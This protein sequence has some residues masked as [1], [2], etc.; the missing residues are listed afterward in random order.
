VE[1]KKMTRSAWAITLSVWRALFLRDAIY[2]LFHR[3]GA[4]VWL[5]LEPVL[6][7]AF[8]VFIFTV[9]RVKVVGGID[10]ALWLLAGMLG[11]FMFRRTMNAS[12]A[13]IQMSRALFTYRQVKPV[14]SVLVRAATEGVLMFIIALAIFIGAAILGLDVLPDNGFGV[15]YAFFTLWLLG[16][17]VGLLMSV[18]KVIIAEIGDVFNILMTPLYLLSGV[19]FPI[20]AVPQPYRDWLLLNPIVH[21]LEIMRLSFATHYVGIS[22]LDRLYPLLSGLVLVFLGLVVQQIYKRKVIEL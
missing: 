16:L 9:I 4:W 19:I 7:M 2:R 12:M 15:L 22:E 17:A 1:S 6:Q 13:G 10:T 3:R 21:S 8:L 20:A 18:P 11:F 5:M 14:D